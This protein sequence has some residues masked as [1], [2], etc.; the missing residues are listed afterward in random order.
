MTLGAARDTELAKRMGQA[1]ASELKAVG[2]NMDFAPVL[3]VN[4]N[5]LNRL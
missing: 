1:V 4:C 5:S 2:I 3:D